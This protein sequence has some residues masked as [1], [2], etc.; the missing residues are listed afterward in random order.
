[1]KKIL[2]N[3]LLL[4]LFIFPAHAQE[5]SVTAAFDTSKILIGDQIHF[6]VTVMQ[7]AEIP[8]DIPVFTD[9]LVKNIEILNGP[10]TDTVRVEDGNIRITDRYLI[11]SFDSG[12]YEIKPLYVEVKRPDG[13]QRFYTDY[14]ILEV[15]KY[16]IAPEDSTARIYD[17]IQPYRAPLTPWEV[18]PWI[19]VTILAGALVWGII[20]FIRKHRHHESQ[21][22]QP[23]PVESAHIIAFRELEKLKS[24]ELWQKGNFKQYYTRLTEILRTYLEN[25]YRVYSLELTTAETL[26]ALLKTGFRKDETYDKLKQVLTAADL[27]KFAKY[28][29][30]PEENVIHFDYSWS[31]VDVTR[32]VLSE[33]MNSDIRKEETL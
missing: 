30:K 20:I 31:F 29:P 18:I 5:I 10:E 3:I 13:L 28:I 16:K 9:T 21:S 4:Q 14:A 22:V 33:T 1:M 25:R 7:P 23:L 15:E 6:T 8:L 32:E 27:V 12:F 24:E 19:L 17:I 2:G 11:T 26:D